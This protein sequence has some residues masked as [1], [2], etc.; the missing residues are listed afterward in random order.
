MTEGRVA[1]DRQAGGGLTLREMALRGLRLDGV[2][3]ID[4][5]CHLGPYM[6]FYQPKNAAADLVRTMDRVGIDQA[7]VFS[8]L[9][10]TI[11]MRGGN[12]LSLA[13]ARA[14]PDRLL[15]YV[16]PDPNHA[17]AAPGELER[18]FG[19]GARGIKFHTQLH[20]YPFDGPA[21]HPAFAFADAHRLPLISHGVGTP[22]TLRRVARA[23]PGAHFIVAHAG[24]GGGG[25]QGDALLRV[26]AEEPNV[27]LDLASSV[28]RLGAFAEVVQKVGAHKLHYGSDIPWM[29]FTHQIGRVLLA[30]ISE[31]DKR[32]ILGGNLAALLATRR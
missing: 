18:C 28:G 16:V 11:D 32:A 19:A 26:A 25:P 17:E 27:H 1:K 14:F 30:P 23:Y 4:G 29:C 21:Y 20:N 8:T 15:A 22:D 12:D 31:A 24:A 6:G 5:H 7:C 2:R 13:A 10:V 9:A 3:V